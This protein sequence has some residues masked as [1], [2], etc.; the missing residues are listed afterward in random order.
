M[1]LQ[2]YYYYLHLMSKA[3]ATLGLDQLKLK[4]GSSI[5]W[6]RA[7]AI[8]LINLQQADGSWVNANGRWWE[9]DPI[10]VTAYAVMALEF[11]YPG[12]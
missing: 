2:G 3:L 8:R 5:D 11:L 12:L 7:L 6:R 9:S 10:L 4:D 1:G